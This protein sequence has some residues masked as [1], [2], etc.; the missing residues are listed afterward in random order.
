MELSELSSTPRC[1][2]QQI[3][4]V[5]TSEITFAS[6]SIE[7]Q[8]DCEF[9]SVPNDIPTPLLA[10]NHL[11]HLITSTLYLIETKFGHRSDF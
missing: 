1:A 10:L 8:V 3:S 6:L 7:I 2:S 11:H 4:L 9:S 5:E